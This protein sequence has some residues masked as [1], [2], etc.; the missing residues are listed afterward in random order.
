MVSDTRC[1]VAARIER[2]ESRGATAV[3]VLQYPRSYSIAGT[4]H[5]VAARA[6]RALGEA[7]RG[8]SPTAGKREG[9]SF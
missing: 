7:G 2:R 1:Y 5:G 4:V 3:D 9:I 8:A 6:A